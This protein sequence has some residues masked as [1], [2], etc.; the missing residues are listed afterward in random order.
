M[1]VCYSQKQKTKEDQK[2]SNVM[3]CTGIQIDKQ[4]D[5]TKCYKDNA[6][7]YSF[8]DTRRQEI[9]LN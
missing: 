4:N 8:K 6:N 7:E 3:K 1:I 9:V 5:F 2:E